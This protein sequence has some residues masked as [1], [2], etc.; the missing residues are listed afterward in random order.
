MT[1]ERIILLTHGGFSCLLKPSYKLFLLPQ[2]SYGKLLQWVS[3]EV[4]VMNKEVGTG[5]FS[6]KSA[7][8]WQIWKEGGRRNQ[9]PTDKMCKY[10]EVNRL[11]QSLK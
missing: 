1:G 6:I 11:K 2:E 3:T 5:L 10:H 7:A 4:T 8:W 9:C